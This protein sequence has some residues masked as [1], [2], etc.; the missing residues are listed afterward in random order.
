MMPSSWAV[1]HGSS[2]TVRRPVGGLGR[3][4]HAGGPVGGVAGRHVDVELAGRPADREP[5]AGLGLVALG[6]ERVGDQLST[7][8]RGRRAGC[9]WSWRSPPRRSSRCSRPT[10][11]RPCGGRRPRT[12]CSSSRASVDLGGRS[13]PRRA[14]DV[15]VEVDRSTPSGS[16]RPTYSSASPNTTLSRA[17]ASVSAM[18]AW[19][20][21]AGLREA[22][23]AVADHPD[24][25]ALRTRPTTSDSIS[26]S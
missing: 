5:E 20:K 24:A 2:T 7:T 19:S 14:R 23:A 25:D 6:G 4:E 12:A 26:P 18:T 21:R 22:L 17:S 13:A 10:R 15:Q 11:R 3:A 1:T 9:R 8:S 16:A